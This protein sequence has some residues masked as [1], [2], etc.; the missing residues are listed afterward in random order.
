MRKIITEKN[1]KLKEIAY[2]QGKKLQSISYTETVSD[3]IVDIKEITLIP[4]FENHEKFSKINEEI[5]IHI[6]DFKDGYY[7]KIE[8]Q[9]YPLSQKIT[10]QFDTPGLKTLKIINF[11]NQIICHTEIVILD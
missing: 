8:E 10:M 4:R 2:F 6:Q 3:Q 11:N 7:I 9:Y 1:E 5:H